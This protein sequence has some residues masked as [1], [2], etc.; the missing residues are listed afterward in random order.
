M[1]I[2][3]I[4]LWLILHRTSIY[5]NMSF[6][7]R[8]IYDKV[9]FCYRSLK[10]CGKAC[11]DNHCFVCCYRF[12]ERFLRCKCGRPSAHD[13][14]VS[15][16]ESSEVTADASQSSMHG[17]TSDL[18][19]RTRLVIGLC[20]LNLFRS[21]LVPVLRRRYKKQWFCTKRYVSYT[22]WK[23]Y[24]TPSNGLV[25]HRMYVVCCWVTPLVCVCNTSELHFCSFKA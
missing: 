17:A 22:S 25:S 21:N 2:A 15:S 18:L 10:G 16:D 8:T 24:C 12:K 9:S 14:S 20:C 5:K 13:G 19:W 6:C 1:F 3:G 23:Q 7:Y 11:F 4:T